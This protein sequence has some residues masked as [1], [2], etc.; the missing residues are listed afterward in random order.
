MSDWV[1]ICDVSRVRP[2]RG[3]AALV[4]DDAVAIFRLSPTERSKP[5]EWR[6]V[7]HIDPA[8]GSPVMARGLVGSIGAAPL[9]V[10]TVASPL[11]KQRYNLR[12]GHCLDDETLRLETYEVRVV[13]ET[14]ECLSEPKVTSGE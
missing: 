3:V 4:G 7:S 10:P 11:F 14:V 9:I 1:P 5:D 2:D 12:T 8:T 13:G 6:G